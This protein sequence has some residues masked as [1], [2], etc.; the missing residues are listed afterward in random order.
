MNGWYVVYILMCF[1][2]VLL[3]KINHL[4]FSD[5]QFWIWT[6]VPILSYTAGL[7][8]EDQDR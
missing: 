4:G 1:L 8:W 6:L 7:G 3:L 5:L 2:N